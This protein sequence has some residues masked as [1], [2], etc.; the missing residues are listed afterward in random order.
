LSEAE[1]AAVT[2]D[3]GAGDGDL[4]L[5]VADALD[6]VSKALSALRNHF[7]GALGLADPNEF[8]FLWIYEF[9]LLEWDEEGQRWDATHNPFSGFLEEDR[10][11]LQ[12]D[13]GAVRAKQYDLTLN[14][15]EIGGG[16][17]RMHTRADQ[18]MIF[19]MMGHS[20]EAQQERFGAILDAL[21]FGAPPHGGIAMGIDR[22]V[23][24]AADE[25][26]IREVMAFPKNQ[27]GIDLMFEAPSPIE[28]QQLVD[29]G[30]AL[31]PQREDADQEPRE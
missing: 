1:V 31:R 2:T 14:G 21:E 9:P 20:P 10:P 23:M 7:G 15:F 28:D 22:W 18:S 4:V 30:L 26:N 24:F 6:V 19:E 27:R 8:H 29:V 25:N 16:S 13:P 11:L 3:I 5:I 12:S 17:V